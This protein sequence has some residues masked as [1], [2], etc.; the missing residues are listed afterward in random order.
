MPDGINQCFLIDKS[1]APDLELTV[2][3]FNV[4]DGRNAEMVKRSETLHE[5][6]VFVARV[7]DFR[8]ETG[9]LDTAM[10]KAIDWCIR[11]GILSDFL[12]QR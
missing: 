3:V 5:Y 11:H 1:A 9:D 2:K 10:P 12:G 8:A 6:A 4:N 7:R